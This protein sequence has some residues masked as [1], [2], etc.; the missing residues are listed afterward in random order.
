MTPFHSVG[1]RARWK[2]VYDE[3][4]RLDIGDT[5]TYERMGVLLDLHPRQ[6]RHN[7]RQALARAAR[8]YLEKDL[9]ALDA[10]TGVGYR[11]VEPIE[12][13]RIAKGRGKKAGTQLTIAYKV[14]THVDMTGMGVETRS[15][16]ENIAMGFA[17]QIE[18]NRR[19]DKAIRDLD[20][21]METVS[22]KVDRTEE[23]LSEVKD[24]MR[25]LEEKLASVSPKPSA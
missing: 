9:R 23:E 13:M 14:L 5:L 10:V 16:F 2:V 24:R 25:R 3:L 6:D 18:I 11:I 19:H 22:V 7:I 15:S 8:E 4:T 1:E 21:A 12:H 20:Q 17:H